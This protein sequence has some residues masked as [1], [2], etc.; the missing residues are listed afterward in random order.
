MRKIRE[1]QKD[2]GLDPDGVIGRNTLGAMS[3]VW[4]LSGNRL[5][6][7][8]GQTHHESAGFSKDV[9]SL[10]YSATG[11]KNTFAYYKKYS[12]EANIDGRTLFHKAD[13]ET[14]ANKVYWDRN[15]SA[16]HRLGNKSWGDGWRFR[17]RGPLQITGRYNYAKLENF[18]GYDVLQHPERVSDQLYWE[19][20]M[21]FF[22]ENNLWELADGDS[23]NSISK[24]SVRINGGLNGLDDRIRWTRYYIRLINQAGL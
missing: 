9:E 16:T 23:I 2:N 8:L 13:Q 10:N 6:N 5:G 4:G 7:F 19:S 21:W 22:S 24:L 14:I 1:F 18:V 20:G 17:G 15:R 11:L 12:A 3:L